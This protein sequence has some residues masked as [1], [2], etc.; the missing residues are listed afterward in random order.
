MS[1]PLS[2][3]SLIRV[4]LVRE[5]NRGMGPLRGAAPLFTSSK[6]GGKKGEKGAEGGT[7][8]SKMVPV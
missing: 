3:K 1:C 5:K 4:G 6:M 2:P 7:N 8:A